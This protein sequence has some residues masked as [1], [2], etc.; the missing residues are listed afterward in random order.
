MSSDITKGLLD[1]LTI[2]KKVLTKTMKLVEQAEK[3]IIKNSNLDHLGELL[4]ESSRLKFQANPKAGTAP[5]IEFLDMGIAAGALG[6]KVLGAGGG[7]FCLFWLKENDKE[8]FRHK[9]NLGQEVPFR[10]DFSGSSIVAS[11]RWQC[12]V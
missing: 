3:L 8:R 7:G 4:N 12:L 10:I 9:F 11:Q 5:I 6:G 1:N 2:N